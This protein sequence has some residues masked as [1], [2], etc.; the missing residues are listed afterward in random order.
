MAEA[1]KAGLLVGQHFYE[2]QLVFRPLETLE[3]LF[4][5]FGH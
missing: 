4:L 5:R 2:R 1:A 3:H